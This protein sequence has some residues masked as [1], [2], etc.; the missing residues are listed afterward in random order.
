MAHAGGRP[1]KLTKEIQDSVANYLK[2]GNFLWTAAA[3]NGLDRRTIQNWITRGKRELQRVTAN[4][5]SKIRQSEALY[6][7]FFRT[8]EKA[9]AEAEARFV[10]LM[11]Q[12]AKEDPQ[13]AYKML[14]SGRYPLW[15]NNGQQDNDEAPEPEHI[16]L[17]DMDALRA[18]L[19]RRLL[20]L[21]DLPVEA[22]EQIESEEV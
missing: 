1:T 13:W 4:K 2:M 6:V 20:K 14:M 10:G 18:K 21:Q 5:A 9:S 12:A 3:L 19:T 17:E 8:V 16:G 22:L 11:Y 7:E 15:K